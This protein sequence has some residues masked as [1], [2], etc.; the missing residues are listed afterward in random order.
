MRSCGSSPI[1]RIIF[2]K[3][4]RNAKCRN[5]QT[6]KTKDLVI[7]AIVWVQ[8]PSSASFSKKY[9]RNAEVSELADEQD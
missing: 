6:S 3:Y 9:F 4:F 8:V 5:W 7:N 2:K 1:F